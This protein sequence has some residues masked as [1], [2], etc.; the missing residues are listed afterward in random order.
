MVHQNKFGTDKSASVHEI[1]R[2]RLM[3]NPDLPS[4]HLECECRSD[5]LLT[6]EPNAFTVQNHLSRISIVTMNLGC[7]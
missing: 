2:V 7:R 3:A 6:N 1:A 5:I 4:S